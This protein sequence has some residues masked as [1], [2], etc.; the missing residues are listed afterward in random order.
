MP[1]RRAQLPTGPSLRLYRRLGFGNLIDLSVLDTRQ[2]RSDQACG[3]ET[4]TGC[5]D[6]FDPARTMLGA[7]QERWLLDTLSA[8]RARWTILGQ[9][10]PTFAR[11]FVRANPDRQFSMDKWDG[12]VAARHRLYAG[13]RDTRAP[14]P[15]VLSGDVH[16]HYGADLKL[17]FTNPESETIGV[18]LTN[19]SISSNGDGADVTSNW[20]TIRADNLHITFHS[21]RRGY[22]SCTATQ[23]TLQADF[24]IVEQVSVPGAPV[25]TGG[26]LVVEAGKPG[27]VRA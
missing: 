10:V 2:H 20:E 17:D 24:R 6:A 21:G 15:V 9:Q 8:A 25:S 12:Y 27:S 11:D 5:E 26:S 3:G 1:L 14:D 16:S 4:T 18:E 7:E 22:I 23:A 19:S 13:I